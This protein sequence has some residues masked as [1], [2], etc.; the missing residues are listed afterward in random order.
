MPKGSTGSASA[1]SW[2]AASP[3]VLA[4]KKTLQPV[5]PRALDPRAANTQEHMSQNTYLVVFYLSLACC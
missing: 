4:E 2:L 3:K 5:K 1:S